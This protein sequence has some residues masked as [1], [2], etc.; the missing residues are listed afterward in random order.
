MAA[1]ATLRTGLVL[2]PLMGLLLGGLGGAR[3]VSPAWCDSPVGA[4][5]AGAEA[6]TEAA[7]PRKEESPDQVQS[8]LG[9][10]LEALD[11]QGYRVGTGD[12]IQIHVWDEEELSGEFLVMFRGKI[13]YPLIGEVEVSG[14]TV[15]QIAAKLKDLLG[16][17]YLKNPNVTVAVKDYRSQKVYIFGKVL[18]P[19]IHILTEQT[20]V[21]KVLLD[22][23]GPAEMA[24]SLTIL[25]FPNGTNS[26]GDPSQANGKVESIRVNISKLLGEGDLSQNKKVKA[27][28]ILLV[29]ARGTS[30]V[31]AGTD[32]FYVLGEVSNPGVYEMGD[33]YTVLNAI[34]DAGGFT[35]YAATNKMRLLRGEGEAQEVIVVRGGDLVMKGDKAADV[36]LQPGD[37]LVV[38][39]SFF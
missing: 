4:K 24:D 18:R 33:G 30:P 19:G 17:D 2:T 3:Y 29:S 6:S 14:L 1:I 26:S 31:L 23:G 16:R 13:S 36:N 38:P 39:E 12:T 11:S 27:G 28:D 32:R 34:L 15:Q 25:R 20:D 22:I 37:I 9:Q 5:V 10:T 7:Q 21:L 8:P 35:E